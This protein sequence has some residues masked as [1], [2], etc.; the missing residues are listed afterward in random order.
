MYNFVSGGLE[1]LC[2]VLID[3]I[4]NLETFCPPNKNRF[5]KGM[6]FTGKGEGKS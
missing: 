1:Q 5:V 6:L 3:C 4:I 2:H